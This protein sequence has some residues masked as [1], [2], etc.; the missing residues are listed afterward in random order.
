MQ[1][2]RAP[3]V[4]REVQ[5]IGL[6][7]HTQVEGTQKPLDTFLL[8]VYTFPVYEINSSFLKWKNLWVL[9]GLSGDHEEY[10]RLACG[11]VWYGGNGTLFRRNVLPQP[12]KLL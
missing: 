6:H 7:G 9:L 8:A 1:W 12:Q 4:A 5:F 10:C 2:V 3:Q 11:V